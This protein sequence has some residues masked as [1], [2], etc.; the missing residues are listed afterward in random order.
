MQATFSKL[1]EADQFKKQELTASQIS[2][3]FTRVN[4][5]TTGSLKEAVY[6]LPL[7]IPSIKYFGYSYS[8]SRISFIFSSVVSGIL[9]VLASSYQQM[10]AKWSK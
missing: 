2:T 10:G 7:L 3:S 6:P 9:Y 5:Y 1:R 4:T 8:A